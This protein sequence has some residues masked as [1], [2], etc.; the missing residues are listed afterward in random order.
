MQRGE[1]V[2]IGIGG[3]IGTGKTTVC[4]IFEN[5][6]AHYISADE[7]GWEILPEV[8]NTLRKKF[9][10]LIMDGDK[11]DRQKLGTVIFSKK[12]NLTFLNELTHPILVEKIINRIKNIE[13]GIVVIDA[14]L[15]FNWPDIL[16]KIDYTILVTADDKMKIARAAEK[17]VNKNLSRKILNFQKKD[18]EISKQAN[19]IIKNNG[20]IKAL[21]Q[22][23][24]IIY[25]EIKNDC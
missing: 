7:V 21:K 13:S 25:K 5:F 22:E 4:K 24:Q 2:V 23:C 10:E 16:K 12:E 11:I 18:S 17:G 1:K 3:N 15:L 14:A 19:F 8:K 6:G 20:T 9:G